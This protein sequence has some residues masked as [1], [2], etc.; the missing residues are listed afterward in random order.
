MIT[1]LAARWLLTAVFAAAGSER[2]CRGAA[3]RAR[4]TRRAGFRPCSAW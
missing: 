3:L 4:R 1:A 2:R